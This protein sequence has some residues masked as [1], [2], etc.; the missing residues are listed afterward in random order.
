MRARLTPVVLL[1]LGTFGTSVRAVGPEDVAPLQAQTPAPESPVPA[2]P[3]PAPETQQPQFELF[4]Q[5]RERR[6]LFLPIPRVGQ[7]QVCRTFPMKTITADP[8]IDPKFLRPVPDGGTKYSMREFTPPRESLPV[9]A[10]SRDVT[11]PSPCR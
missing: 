9:G 5:P 4:P 10:G 3:Q 11:P 2:A 8:A 7:P 6:P 1:A